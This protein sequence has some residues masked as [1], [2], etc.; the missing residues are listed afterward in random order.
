M[1]AATH[2]LA[3]AALAIT[4]LTPAAAGTITHRSPTCHYVNQTADPAPVRLGP[5]KKHR[6]TAELPPSDTPVKATCAA[7]GRGP[8]HWVRVK[9]GEQKGRWIWRNRLQAWT[10]E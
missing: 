1:G 4:P 6:K 9:D 10:G 3:G 5:G 8:G 2:L 7:R